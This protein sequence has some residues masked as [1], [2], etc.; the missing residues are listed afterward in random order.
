MSTI[1][2]PA[3][4]LRELNLVKMRDEHST[5]LLKRNIADGCNSRDPPHTTKRRKCH[6]DLGGNVW[7]QLGSAAKIDTARIMR[8]PSSRCRQE[9]EG[10]FELR[11]ESSSEYVPVPPFSIVDKL[12]C[13]TE[14]PHIPTSSDRVLEHTD[15]DWLSSLPGEID[16]ALIASLSL[17]PATSTDTDAAAGGGLRRRG[18]SSS[19]PRLV[20]NQHIGQL[21]CAEAAP[22]PH[23][24]GA[25]VTTGLLA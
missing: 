12:G 6:S 15:M 24:D 16:P 1:T 25:A 23:D 19:R 18:V 22:L 7:Q 3:L 17:H 11:L 20:Y 14:F 9:L 5:F 21:I 13:S 4:L 8:N 2:G 10:C